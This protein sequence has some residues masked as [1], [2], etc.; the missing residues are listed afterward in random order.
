MAEKT[1]PADPNAMCLATVGR[2]GRPS[3]RMVLLKHHD[4][5]GFTFFTNSQSRK[6]E[7]LEHNPYVALCFHWK[8]LT[9]QIRIEGKIHK[10]SR[11]IT[12]AYFNTRTRESRIASCASKQSAPLDDKDIYLD[13][14]QELEEQFKDTKIIPCPD[15]WNGYCVIPDR[16][17]FWDQAPHRTHDRIVFTRGGAGQWQAQR[18]YP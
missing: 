16:I 4:E 9:K 17:E 18:L 2:D 6:G 15:H 12:Q 14:I 10:V 7:E 8:S 1:E 11:D 5:N 3:N 13:R